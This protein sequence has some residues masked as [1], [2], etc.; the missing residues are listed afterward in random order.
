MS[1]PEHSY[2]R[3]L[4][5]LILAA[6]EAQGFACNGHLLALNS[7]ENRVYQIGL[8]DGGF[9]IAKFY[10]PERWSNE[11]ILEE[12]A[13]ALEL[14]EHEIPIVAPLSIA[15]RTLLEYEGFR[16]ALFPRRGGRWPELDDPDNLLWLGRYLGR[17]HRVGQ[18]RPFVHR[19][20]LDINSFGRR[21][22]DYLLE[23]H[24]IPDHLMTAY[25]TLARDLLEQIEQAYQRAGAITLIRTHGDC[26]PG[27]ILWR[28]DGPQIVDLD[29]CR[30]APAIQDLW[31]LISGERRDQAMALS[32]LLEGYQEF[33]EFD[34]REL[35]L[36]EALR[37]LRLMH[38]AAWLARR[39]QDPAF[40][41]AFPWFYHDRY[42]E[43]HILT[44]RE[45]LAALN[46]P[47]LQV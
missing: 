35:H 21:S 20:T 27:N 39:S 10:R 29:D 42:W 40:Q 41:Q 18:A 34:P 46:E 15:G 32:E 11:A 26:H 5:D 22:M 9:V 3:L 24:F 36:V 25:Q 14:A 17:L 37:T 38:Y 45:Q 7:Y 44:L 31:M 23:H 43:E 1:A 2:A 47:P 12:H 6:I 13:F 16:L 30:M 33:A 19:P 8:E 4:P 28:E